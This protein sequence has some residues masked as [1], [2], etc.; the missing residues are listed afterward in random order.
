VRDTAAVRRW[1]AGLALLGQLQD[2][3][4]DLF[5]GHATWETVQAGE[6]L[7]A[8]GQDGSALWFL[9]EGEI[10]LGTP[11]G[12]VDA[13]ARRAITTPGY[14]VGWDGVVWPQRHRW[15]AVAATRARLL[16]VPRTVIDDRCRTDEAFAARFYQLLL[17]LAGAQLRSQH[18]RLVTGRY[19]DETDAVAALV[20]SRADELRVTSPLH[21]I[22]A[23][24]RSRPTL[25]DAFRALEAVRDG[26]DAVEA[27]IAR[28]A[29]DV[30]EGVRRELRIY[31]GLQRVYE[32]VAS[33]PRDVDPAEVRA[34]ACRALIDLFGHI[35]HRIAGLDRLPPTPGSL[36]LCNHLSSHPITSLPN[37]FSLIP[38]THFVSSMI[39]YRTYGRAP[40]RVVRDSHWHE[41]GH[42]RYYARLGY[43]MVPSS[44]VGPLPATQRA[45][46]YER[47]VADAAAVL[48]TG[49]DLIICPEGRPGPTAGS[50]G[51]LRIGAFQ[52]AAGLNP[53]PLIVPVALAHF[54]QRLGRAVLGAVVAEPFR[55]S[56]VVADPFDRDQVARFVNDLTP[57]YRA[58]VQE[59]AALR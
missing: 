39:L 6:R 1:F 10:I 12:A 5:A 24:L 44:E 30:L 26:H 45:E 43:V 41:A 38:D 29:L 27:E 28:E 57:R 47:F 37:G 58:W 55:M 20:A 40:V 13:V 56:D 36:V 42:A 14:P 53:E 51:R 31:L 15:D 8:D 18:T 22:P 25:G 23:Y 34:R 16:R 21:R 49:H 52:L 9:V 35:E 32:A 46:R 4:L 2:V 54:D 59:A 11:C 3:D 19:D 48:R 50:P 7:H 33:A 17:W